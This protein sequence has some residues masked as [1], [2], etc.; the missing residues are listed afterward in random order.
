M[1]VP[2]D[3]ASDWN[4]PY[5]W[6]R[7]RSSQVEQINLFLGTIMFL[8]TRPLF[9]VDEFDQVPTGRIYIAAVQA[10][11]ELRR[12]LRCK[13][14]LSF[15]SCYLANTKL[16][17]ARNSYW[18]FLALEGCPAHQAYQYNILLK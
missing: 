14:K 2:L 11:A 8:T 6:T 18:S 1:R 7:W 3:E 10:L 16:S 13:S 9:E 4:K 15:L 5:Y 12:D 17:L